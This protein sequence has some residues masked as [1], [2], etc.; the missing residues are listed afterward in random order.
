MNRVR[1]RDREALA[2]DLKKIYRQN[3][4]E[5]FIGDKEEH[6]YDEC[7]REVYKGGE[8]E[9]QGG[10]GISEASEC[11]EGGVFGGG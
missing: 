5:G 10:G 7:G 6:I 8:E 4:R 2:V 9:E 3:S 11:G 1:K